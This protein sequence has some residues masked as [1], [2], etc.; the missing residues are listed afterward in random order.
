MS[1]RPRRAAAT[2]VALLGVLAVLRPAVATAG[3]AGQAQSATRTVTSGT[4]AV[5][6]TLLTSGVPAP[7]ALPLTFALG[8]VPVPQYFE[9]V[10]T[11]TITVTAASYSV[12]VTGGLSGT[13]AVTLTACVGASWDRTLGT[14][15]GTTTTIGSWTSASSSAIS[16]PAVPGTPS[17]RLSIKASVTG[18]SL[19]SVTV[20]TV[21]ISVS[22]GPTRQIRAAT[23]T[24]S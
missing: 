13:T 14:C 18:G 24:N 9:A 5:V 7:G 22:S 12:A 16:S 20:A 10:N 1:I 11:G 6:P 3:L 4:W 21:N 2:A 19:T 17:S 8:A 23:T 15:S